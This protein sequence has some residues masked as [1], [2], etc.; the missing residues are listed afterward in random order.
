MSDII[1][2]IMLI[3]MFSIYGSS[4]YS[5]LSLEGHFGDKGEKIKT[6][7]L[8]YNLK[9]K[10]FNEEDYESYILKFFYLIGFITLVLSIV[11]FVSIV[12]VPDRKKSQLGLC[13]FE[14]AFTEYL[15]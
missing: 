9:P 2:V 7:L 1:K 12:L 15:P 13:A 10:K 5:I 6:K 8:E 3:I 11:L 4:M 14:K